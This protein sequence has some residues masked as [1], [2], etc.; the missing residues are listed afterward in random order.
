MRHDDC[1]D[2]PMF[3]EIEAA[4]AQGEE[5]AL[6]T[7]VK[8]SGAA[9]CAPGA[10]LLVRAGGAT[11]GTLGGADTDG[12]VARDALAAL[13]AGQANLFTYHLDPAGS[14]SVGSC[15]ATLE[16]FIESLR[17][18]PRLL[19]AGS[20]HVGQALARLVAPLG[21]RVALLD[22]RSEFA[23][24]ASLPAGIDVAV[25]EMP[26]L[27][28][29]RRPDAATW[30]VIATRGHRTD[31]DVLRAALAGPTAYVGMIGSPSKV[32]NIFS[33]LLASGVSPDD[34]AR[35][36]APIGLDLGAQTPGE[37]AL[38]IAAEMLMIRSGASGTPLRQQVMPLVE[39]QA[40]AAKRPRRAKSAADAGEAAASATR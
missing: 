11:S 32:R 26:G 34:V 2:R 1:Q 22:D 35:V 9:P 25:G 13:A 12:R 4:L 24:E 28:L 19:I 18:E 40:A 29:D 17:P 30:I 36:H 23:R 21:W 6:A 37:I 33:K 7:V 10:R 39:A 5:V 27:L 3:Q 8:T 15:G 16:V 38:S 31:E 20:G 14:D